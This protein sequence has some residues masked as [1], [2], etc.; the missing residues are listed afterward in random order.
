M[1]PQQRE[2]ALSTTLIDVDLDGSDNNMLLIASGTPEP[3]EAQAGVQDHEAPS[4]GSG[5]DG[6]SLKGAPPQFKLRGAPMRWP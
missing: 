3:V 5:G 6:T 2:Q 1:S 4:A